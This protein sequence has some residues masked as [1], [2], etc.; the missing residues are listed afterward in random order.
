[1]TMTPMTAAVMNA[2]PASRAG[3]A[4]A[5]TNTSREIGGNFGIAFIGALL[6]DRFTSTLRDKL[7]AAGLPVAAQDAV[8]VGAAHGQGASGPGSGVDSAAVTRMV[9][10]S[11]IS[12]VH[13]ALVVASGFLVLAAVVAAV[14]IRP[15]R[16]AT[17]SAPAEEPAPVPA[18]A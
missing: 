8:V 12:G 3:M 6:V 2:V 16:R 15:A 14:T 9:N 4:S 7:T 18:T 1:M 5:T 11:F 13:L 17:S 10:E